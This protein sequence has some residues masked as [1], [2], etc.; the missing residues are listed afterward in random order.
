[1]AEVVGQNTPASEKVMGYV[2]EV[3]RI[4]AQV[5]ELNDIKTAIYARAKSE[6]FSPPGIRYVVKMR[7][8]KPQV[9]EEEETTRDVYMHAA[10]MASEPPIYRQIAALTKDSVAGDSLLDAMKQL[11]PQNGE[12]ICT[13]AGKQMRLWRDKDGQPQSA[14]YVAVNIGATVQTRSTLPA[15]KP[16]EVPSCTADE[17]EELGRQAYRDNKPIIENPFPFGDARV[18]RWDRGWR[19]ESG[20]DG[21][22]N[23]S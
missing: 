22:G 16:R 11:V 7:K 1:M 23:G 4:E 12:I 9:R 13:I 3:E 15:S 20:S 18:P 8:K 2:A 19:M 6:G 14:E 17:A 21:M 10:G 5:K